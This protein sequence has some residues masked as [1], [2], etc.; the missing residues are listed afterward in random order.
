[1]AA[2]LGLGFGAGTEGDDVVAGVAVGGEMLLGDSAAA[3]EGD[4]GTV[5]FRRGREPG[6]VGGGNG[7][8]SGFFAEAVGLF[9]FDFLCFRH[10]RSGRG[11]DGVVVVPGSGMGGD[12]VTARQPVRDSGP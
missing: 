10:G 12:G 7:F 11:V 4:V 6:E 2:L 1:M 9:G 5:M 8:T 3:D